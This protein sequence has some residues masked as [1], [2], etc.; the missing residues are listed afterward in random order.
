[1]AERKET[2]DRD[3]RKNTA[4]LSIATENSTFTGSSSS[5]SSSISGSKP[6]DSETEESEEPAIGESF[7]IPEEYEASFKEALSWLELELSGYNLLDDSSVVK[8]VI[9]WLKTH[10]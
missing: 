7:Q 3:L 6:F 5:S 4:T 2:V 8:F 10:P 1:M 9:P